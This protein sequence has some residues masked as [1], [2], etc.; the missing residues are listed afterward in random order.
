M[1]ART[2][3][4]LWAAIFGMVCGVGVYFFSIAPRATEKRLEKIATSSRPI[5]KDEFLREE[6]IR[7]EP[8]DPSIVP[9]DAMR[10]RDLKQY[11]GYRSKRDIS[12][13]E[14]LRTSDFQR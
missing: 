1:S 14:V 5:R 7:L 2:G 10:A 11:G 4:F 9:H 3:L 12:S 8:V 13:G 6:M